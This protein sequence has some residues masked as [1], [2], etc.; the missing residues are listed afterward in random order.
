MN[1]EDVWVLP[2]DGSSNGVQAPEKMIRAVVWQRW[3]TDA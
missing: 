3:P 2:N 1:L